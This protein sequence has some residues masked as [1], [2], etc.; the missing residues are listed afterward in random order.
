MKQ[1]LVRRTPNGM[2]WQ[3]YNVEN[4]FERDILT[5]NAYGNDFGHVELVDDMKHEETW[6]G[7]R[8]TD[9]WAAILARHPADPGMKTPI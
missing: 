2:I 5:M 1:L 8:D 6:P 4:Q 3:V 7:W 9:G